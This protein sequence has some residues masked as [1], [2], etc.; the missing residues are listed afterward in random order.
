[1]NFSYIFVAQNGPSKPKEHLHT[2]SRQTPL[3]LHIISLHGSWL[4][5]LKT[6][7]V[8]HNKNMATVAKITLNRFIILQYG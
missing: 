4:Q 5:A 2:P 3:F 6:I 8:L 1:M 7:A